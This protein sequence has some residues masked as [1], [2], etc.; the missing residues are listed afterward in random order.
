MCKLHLVMLICRF[1]KTNKAFFIL[2]LIKVYLLYLLVLV[3]KVKDLSEIVKYNWVGSLCRKLTLRLAQILELFWVEIELMKLK[4]ILKLFKHDQMDINSL[5]L[6]FRW[7]QLQWKWMRE[8]IV[9]EWS[10]LQLKK[11]IRQVCMLRLVYNMLFHSVRVYV[12][13]LINW[14]WVSSMRLTF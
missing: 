4:S 13:G 10:K 7:L 1:W 12:K 14:R 9:R 8:P 3:W 2:I 6:D 11:T 5:V